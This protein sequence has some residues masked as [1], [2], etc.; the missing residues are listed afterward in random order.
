[1]NYSNH[2]SFYS[3]IK[4]LKNN[5][6]LVDT[7]EQLWYYFNPRYFFMEIGLNSIK[8]ENKLPLKSKLNLRILMKVSKEYPKF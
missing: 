5:D 1:M 3:A 4:D 6:I 8:K 7:V 2:G